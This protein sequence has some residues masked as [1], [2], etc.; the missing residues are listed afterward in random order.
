VPEKSLNSLGTTVVVAAVVALLV[1][2]ARAQETPRTRQDALHEAS[3]EAAQCEAYYAFAQKCADN[4]GQTALSAQLQQAIESASK[5]QFTSGKA[6]GMS[7]EAMLASSKLALDAAK[8]SISNSCANIHP[9]AAI[10]DRHS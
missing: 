9:S 7:N 4:A 3:S 6:A 10:P 8:E 1:P 5:F 2:C